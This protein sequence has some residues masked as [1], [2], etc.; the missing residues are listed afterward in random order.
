ME[1]SWLCEACGRVKAESFC[2][3]TGTPVLFC[4]TCF[5]AHYLKQKDK[6]HPTFPVA[7]LKYRE[8]D[9]YFERLQARM[10]HFLRVREQAACFL[11]SIDQCK[12]EVSAATDDLL[13][14]LTLRCRETLNLLDERKKE[15]EAALNAVEA[16]LIEDNPEFS[17]PFAKELRVYTDQ[18]LTD[19]VLFSYQLNRISPDD[20][21]LLN[22][23]DSAFPLNGLMQYPCIHA[24]EL[25]LY[26]LT[27]KT[28]QKQQL[29]RS[30][31]KGTMFCLIGRDEVICLGGYPAT[32]E[33]YLLS[34]SQQLLSKQPNMQTARDYPGVALVGCDVYAFGSYR[35]L[36]RSAEAVHTSEWKSVPNMSTS[37]CCFSPGVH[38]KDIYLA[39]PYASLSRA[40]EVY[41]TTSNAY[42]MLAIQL[43]ETL[44]GYVSAFVRSGELIVLAGG[45]MGRWK[46]GI[47][48][49][50]HITPLKKGSFPL[51]NSPVY[52]VGKEALL[53]DYL[54]GH[55]Y[56]FDTETIT[57]IAP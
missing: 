26:D 19:F 46:I 49:D 36:S 33:V 12:S 31:T 8:E 50:M 29:S 30:F 54:Y 22:M 1:Q 57:L 44:D 4:E 20:L 37:R 15:L 52:L 34:I 47:D 18:T 56:R 32:N 21:L 28:T 11:R 7:A 35:P 41:N 43:P 17:I 14:A 55:L 6:Q 40:I 9:K 27:T 39:S 13:S 38:I 5:C 53:V 42:R 23:Q 45:L 2:Y 24:N 51:G 10:I 3:C 48:E 16:S 25:D